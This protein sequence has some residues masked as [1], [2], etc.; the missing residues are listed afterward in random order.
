[1]LVGLSACGDR[2]LDP[3]E[4]GS[5]PPTA[6]DPAP[7]EDA[8]EVAAA[9]EDLLAAAH[10]ALDEAFGDLGWTIDEDE[11]Q[12]ESRVETRENGTCEY[13]TT[14][15]RTDTALGI[16]V[17]TPEEIVET[18]NPIFESHGL[19]EAD[20]PRGGTGGWLTVETTNGQLTFTLQAKGYAQMSVGAA[21]EGPRCDMPPT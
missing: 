6:F 16:D 7:A 10:G 8:G 11:S 14:V 17:G 3:P 2:Q 13:W 19:Q 20:P 5:V 12:A 15:L 18:L 9:A 4:S 1:M 21:F